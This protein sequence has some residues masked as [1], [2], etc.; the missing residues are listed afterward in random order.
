MGEVYRTKV[1]KT[2]LYERFR[3][4]NKIDEPETSLPLDI[5]SKKQV[6]SRQRKQKEKPSLTPIK[7]EAIFESD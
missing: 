4:G 3:E 5:P 6:S 7:E 2:L 1:A